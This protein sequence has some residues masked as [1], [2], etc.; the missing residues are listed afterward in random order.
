MDVLPAG[1]DNDSGVAV[2]KFVSG[3]MKASIAMDVSVYFRAPAAVVFEHK[4]KII[5]HR[6]LTYNDQQLAALS[7]WQVISCA[8]RKR[9]K[10]RID[11]WKAKLRLV[12]VTKKDMVLFSCTQNSS[13]Q[14]TP[15]PVM[16]TLVKN[17]VVVNINPNLGTQYERML[18]PIEH[19]AVQGLPIFADVPADMKM[20]AEET[21][22]SLAPCKQRVLSGNMMHMPSVGA[23]LMGAMPGFCKSD[24]KG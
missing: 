6:H 16:P 13:H 5:K 2:T 15:G 4:K 8:Q 19:F 18:L 24:M 7:W 9:A 1:H 23:V 14:G 10:P 11:E 20:L 22:M 12:L 3:A 21:F 17:S